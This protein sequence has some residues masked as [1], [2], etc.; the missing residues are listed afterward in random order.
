M[1]IEPR[2]HAPM[3]CVDE[4]TH[5]Q[6][7]APHCKDPALPLFPGRAN[8]MALS[9]TVTETLSLYATFNTKTGE[10]LGKTAEG[11]TSAEF[12]RVSYR[13]RDQPAARQTNPRDP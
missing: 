5:I 10:V 8:G 2:A 12:E 13:H 4:K 6:A 1:C 11:D 3:F 7:Q 9:T